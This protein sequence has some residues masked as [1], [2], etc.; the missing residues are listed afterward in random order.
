MKK[1]KT[2]CIG[3]LG[4][5]LDQGHTQERW[6][7]WRPT[8]SLF[9]H[10]DFLIDQLDLIY[11]KKFK[12]LADI[13]V[14]D[15]AHISPETNVNLH[16]VEFRDPWNFPDV[17]GCLM[18]F[19]KKYPFDPE[20]NEYLIHITTGTHVAQIC[21]FLL[22]ESRY[23][24]AKLIQ[25]SPHKRNRK[26]AKGNF[27]IIDLDLSQYDQI[28]K[29]FE[30]EQMKS[31]SFLKAGIETKNKSF[32]QLIEKIERV[33]INSNAPF[34][35]MGP[36]G[37]GKSSLAKRIHDLKKIKNQIDGPFI[38]V[39]CA[40]IKGEMAMSA[41]FGHVKGSFTGALKDRAGLLKEAN[42]G[43]LFLDEIGELGLDEQAM[44]LKA[45]EEKRFL[46]LGSDKQVESNFQL[47]AGT[48]RDLKESL[49][50]GRFREDLLT[51]INL[52]TFFMPAL[53][54]RIEDIDVNLDYELHKYSRE[55]GKRIT[56]NKEARNAFL[57]FAKSPQALWKANFRD[58]N[59]AITRMGTLAIQGRITLNIVSEEIER[60]R[61]FWEQ[62]QAKDHLNILTAA[63][64]PEQIKTLDLLEQFQ[65]AHVIKV[66][67]G[68]K[69]LSHAGR[70]LFSVSRGKKKK[71]NDA[72]RLRKYL[73]RYDLTW[74]EITN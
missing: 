22:T 20:N 25:T 30:K 23:F 15:I 47:I 6:N 12:E 67:R 4:P 38:E 41:L 69:S 17:F 64:A 74:N 58:L 24:P 50:Q 34:L 26:N 70:T 49:Q 21:E 1:K 3:L 40:T 72:D 35:L 33:A 32:N 14:E 36:T 37:A 46:P 71:S 42:N 7:K 27:T 60:L 10:E 61:L 45:L 31:L 57:K 59:A 53:K 16:I 19:A 66:C 68:S 28:A 29:R 73:Q 43:L 8:V 13:V 55:H 65:L 62:P 63:L 44:L 52:W 11:Q 54:D 2:I 56:F 48:N 39:N 5:T 9:Q 18:D 51:R